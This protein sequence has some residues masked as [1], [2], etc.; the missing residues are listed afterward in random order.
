LNFRKRLNS[1][2]KLIIN[3]GR[4]LSLGVLIIK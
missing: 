2:E 3:I 4:Q 1:R